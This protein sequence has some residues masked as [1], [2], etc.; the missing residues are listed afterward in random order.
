MNIVPAFRPLCSISIE[1]SPPIALG[2][3]RYGEIRVVP[4][5]AGTF[6]GPELA[7]TVLA[8]GTDWQEVAADG[9]LEIRA[10]YLLET[11]RGERIEVRSEGLRTGSPEVLARLARGEDVP[12]SAY[13]FRTSIRLRTAAARLARLNDL[14]AFAHGQRARSTVQ[15]AVFELL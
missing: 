2:P 7:G 6:D 3:T 5:V 4:F 8:G 15:L 11:D 12:P 9:A 13:Y 1:V 14:L 10:R